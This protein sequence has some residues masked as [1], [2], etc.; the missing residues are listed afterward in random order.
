MHDFGLVVWAIVIFAGVISSI[1]K[2]ARRSANAAAK[3]AVPAEDAA[4]RVA[5]ARRLVNAISVRVGTG[6]PTV[7]PPRAQ[8]PA[9]TAQASP[10][11][12][13]PGVVPAPSASFQQAA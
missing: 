11:P 9:P 1:V 8:Q 7:V 6:A 3:P 2:S 13:P 10:T 4:R 5:E 12:P